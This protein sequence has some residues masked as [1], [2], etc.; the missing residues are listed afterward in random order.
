LR[1]ACA[2]GLRDIDGARAAYEAYVERGHLPRE[3]DAKKRLLAF[4][5]MKK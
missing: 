1:G 3:E 4:R 5:G 2:E